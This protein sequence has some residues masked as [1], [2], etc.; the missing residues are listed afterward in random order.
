MEAKTIKQLCQE[1]IALAGYL[2]NNPDNLKGR[3]LLVQ[4]ADQIKNYPTVAV[5]P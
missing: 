4:V 2:K 5:N 1:A 3:E